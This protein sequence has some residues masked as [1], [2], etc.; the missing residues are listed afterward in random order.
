MYGFN[1][2]FEKN[3]KLGSWENH[4]GI[5]EV[6]LKAN[7]ELRNHLSKDPGAISGLLFEIGAGRPFIGANAGKVLEKEAKR[8]EGVARKRHE[9]VL[10]ES[11]EDC[12]QTMI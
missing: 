8:L 5:R 6:L 4:L 3:K 2:L 9:E 1:V 10:L 7:E 11:R 12:E